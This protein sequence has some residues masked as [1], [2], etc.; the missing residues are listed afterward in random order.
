MRDVYPCLFMFVH[1]RNRNTSKL[2][3]GNSELTYMVW[4]SF[5]E[6]YNENAF[7]LLEKLPEV[8]LLYIFADP[9]G[10]D[11]DSDLT[12]VKIRVRPQKKQARSKWPNP[13][14]SCKSRIQIFHKELLLLLRLK[15][16]IPPNALVFCMHVEEFRR[17][18]IS[19]NFTQ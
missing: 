7:D 8:L 19:L 9:G 18:I 14:F 4:V 2:E 15:Y 17:L 12:C 10:F 1:S 16:I 5:A 3:V 6:I 13:M 11:P